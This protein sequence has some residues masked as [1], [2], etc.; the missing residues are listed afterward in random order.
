MGILSR[1]AS[2]KRREIGWWLEEGPVVK[3]AFYFQYNL[4]KYP[5]YEDIIVFMYGWK[6]NKMNARLPQAENQY[7]WGH[8][9]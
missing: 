9:L 6:K 1:C 2:L 4:V 7:F 5:M 3:R 8:P